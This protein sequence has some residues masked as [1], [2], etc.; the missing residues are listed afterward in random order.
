[1]TAFLVLFAAGAV[2]W[3]LR[4]LFITLV[5][6]SRLPAG[7]RSALEHG[8]AAVPAA[9]IA[10]ALAHQGG[11]AA[12]VVPSP[13]LLALV[14]SGAVAWWTRQLAATVAAGVAAFWLL[15]LAWPYLPAVG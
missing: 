15:G 10:T 7:L 8:G 5:P 11:P 6:A 4:V 9:L 2:S 14:A 1:M 3:L 13:A 12:L